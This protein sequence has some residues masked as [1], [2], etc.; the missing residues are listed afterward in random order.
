MRHE[1]EQVRRF[2]EDVWNTKGKEAIPEILHESIQFRGSLG[3]EKNGY[4]E[5]IE[6]LDSVHSALKDYECIIIEIVCEP[7][8]AFAK[9]KFTGI[10]QGEFMG[11]RPTGRRVTWDGAALFHFKDGKIFKLWVLGDLVSLKAQ[12]EANQT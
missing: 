2:Y 1:E 11:F 3:A 9:M 7:S 10:H 8:K 12:L 4:S 5:F 6:Y